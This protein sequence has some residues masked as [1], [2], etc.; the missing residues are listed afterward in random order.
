M[1]AFGTNFF[2]EDYDTNVDVA[3]VDKTGLAYYAKCTGTPP[4]TADKYQKG[5]LMVQTDAAGRGLYENTGTSASPSFDL[6]GNIGST[7]ISDAA[8][9]PVKIGASTSSGVTTN[10]MKSKTFDSAT[11]KALLDGNPNSLT[12]DLDAG[13]Y[14][15]DFVIWTQTA[16]GG[17]GTVKVGTDA[18]WNVASDDDALV[19]AHDLNATGTYKMSV[20]DAGTA[21]AGVAGMFTSATANLTIESST[22]QSASSWVGGITIFYLEV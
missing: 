1:A 5:C 14:L 22:D 6:V 17:A 9:T 13:A 21:T 11:V 10:V 3:F 15:Y 19:A 2:A 18:N 8:V 12:V 16:S 4:T 7:D 20:V